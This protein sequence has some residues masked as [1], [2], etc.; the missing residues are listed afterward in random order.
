MEIHNEQDAWEVLARALAGD[1]PDSVNFCGWPALPIILHGPHFQSSLT[2]T[3]MGGI[4]D[5]ERRLR[6]AYALLCYGHARKRLTREEREALSVIVRVGPGS[7]T[8][9]WDFQALAQYLIDRFAA[10]M[11]NKTIIVLGLAGLL[12]YFGESSFRQWLDHQDRQASLIQERYAKDLDRQHEALLI[13]LA[14]KSLQLAMIQ[15][16][17]EDS[18]LRLLKSWTEADTVQFGTVDLTREDLQRLTANQRSRPT[19]YDIR[20]LFTIDVVNA[21]PAEGLRLTVRDINNN[22]V[23]IPVLIKPYELPS[24]Q[25]ALIKEASFS[26]TPLALS[27]RVK[28]SQ[29]DIQSAL[30]IK[31]EPP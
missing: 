7:S 30:L 10:K 17:A 19:E 3:V 1:A 13:R 14:E 20:G 4:V 31:A 2:T 15:R 11:D 9:E 21:K 16:D 25:L 18:K 8:N 22:G 29:N 12:C 24:D 26:K 5:L 23:I 6:R 28:Q 27:L